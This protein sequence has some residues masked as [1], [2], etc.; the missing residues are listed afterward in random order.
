MLLRSGWRQSE[1]LRLGAKRQNA[2]VV[3]PM[4]ECTVPGIQSYTL[5]M[6]A[7]Y[8][9]RSTLYSSRIKSKRLKPWMSRFNPTLSCSAHYRC[10]MLWQSVLDGFARTAMRASAAELVA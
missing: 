2:I 10:S 8:S 9:A 3:F 1:R 5:A 4:A 6:V 7:P